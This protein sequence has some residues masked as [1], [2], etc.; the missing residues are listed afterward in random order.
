[1]DSNQL[2]ILNNLSKNNT[3]N[4]DHQLVNR[5]QMQIFGLLHPLAKKGI[6]FFINNLPNFRQCESY[7]IKNKYSP[8]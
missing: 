8:F 2:Q 3:F 5:S 4:L 6:F 1:M 7:I